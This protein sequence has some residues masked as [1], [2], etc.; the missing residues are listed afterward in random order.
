MSD[1][2]TIQTTA[3]VEEFLAGVAD[4]RRRA[5]AIAACALM[6]EVTGVEPAMWGPS[7]VGFGS[8]HYQ[9]ASGRQ[10]DAPAVGL[11]PRKQNLT[12]YLMAGFQEYEELLG[13]LGRHTTG[14]SC[15]YLRQ[16][17]DVDEA[18]LRELVGQ[19]FVQFNGRALTP[20]Q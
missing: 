4:P 2:K 5:D 19:A 17:S 8:Y 3:S 15:L 20:E 9:Y 1:A 18:V 14:K 6:R 13:R 7:I 10:G 12:L 11:S 16:L